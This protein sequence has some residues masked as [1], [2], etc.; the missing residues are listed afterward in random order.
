MRRFGLSVFGLLF[1]HLTKALG[2]LTL[3]P[4]AL[5][6]QIN[7][8]CGACSCP[9]KN[10]HSESFLEMKKKKK[11]VTPNLAAWAPAQEEFC[12]ARCNATSKGHEQ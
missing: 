8:I 4:N 5:F 11:K 2:L 6:L 12:R 10:D 1:C 7:S 9:P 3:Q